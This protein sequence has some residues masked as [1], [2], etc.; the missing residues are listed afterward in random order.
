MPPPKPSTRAAKPP[1]QPS[2]PK[3]QPEPQAAAGTE[4]RRKRPRSPLDE[5]ALA[6]RV[7]AEVVQHVQGILETAEGH[8]GS[9]SASGNGSGSGNPRGTRARRGSGVQTEVHTAA[10]EALIKA[11]VTKNQALQSDSTDMV[12]ELEAAKGRGNVLQEQVTALQTRVGELEEDRNFLRGTIRSLQA[13]PAPTRRS[14]S[15]GSQ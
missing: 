12:K 1:S 3:V 14:G 4:D 7:A 13:P 5:E 2:E 6:K 11:L 9:G 10:L 15:S 8:G